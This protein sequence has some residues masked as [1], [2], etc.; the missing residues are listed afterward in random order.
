MSLEILV[1]VKLDA[2]DRLLSLIGIATG[3]KFY[4]PQ[5]SLVGDISREISIQPGEFQ[6]AEVVLEL[7]NSTD[8]WSDI[9][10]S[11]PLMGR[12]VEVLLFDP[13]IGES[14]AVVIAA[15]TISSWSGTAMTIIITAQDLSLRR[16]DT[17]IEDRI[18]IVKFPDLPDET[19]REL[20]P[21]VIGL[22]SSEGT[23]LSNTGALPCYLI[24]P[25]VT[26]AKFQYVACQREVKSIVNVY[27]YGVK[28][29]TGFTTQTSTLG[30]RTYTTIEFD[31]DQRDTSRPDLEITCDIDGITGDGTA[32][33]NRIENPARM[34]EEV[35]LQNGFV[36]GDLD[37]ASFTSAAN[38][39]GGR[40]IAGGFASIDQTETLRTIAEKF[41]S[42]FNLT[43]FASRSGLLAVTAPEPG[44]DIT[45][46]LVSIDESQIVLG[47][48]EMGSPE[49]KASSIV[50]QYAYNY[51]LAQYD[52][53]GVLLDSV[54]ASR[55]N[56]D[57]RVTR[58]MQYVRQVSSAA[59]VANDMLF[60][61]SD[62]R[63][64]VRASADGALVRSIGIGDTIVFKHY[65][66]VPFSAESFR[67]LGA[68]L[69]FD[70]PSFQTALALIDIAADVLTGGTKFL[71]L[72]EDTEFLSDFYHDDIQGTGLGLGLR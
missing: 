70:G 69:V 57:I 40:S 47:S 46:S 31:S 9:I 72:V 22:V 58:P 39:Y 48:L 44:A 65:A 35:L 62:K 42:S 67:V 43:T 26:S 25:S 45:P 11:E 24:D 16:L 14:D 5:L 55:L 68:G 1:K 12:L 50:Y 3:D 21:L 27:L 71:A 23:G 53:E 10:K 37:A 17:V 66:L 33:G 41:S 15:G 2:G 56:G 19:P 28:V 34:W 18:D 54:L 29:T 6:A 59:I 63:V 13:A 20:V 52:S 32:S 7:D 8:I 38:T 49:D 64:V 4:E 60:F 51:H 61:L 36:A 30:G